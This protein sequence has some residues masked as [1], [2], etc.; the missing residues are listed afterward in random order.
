MSAIDRPKSY[1]P[2][3]AAKRWS[4]AWNAAGVYTADP[5][6]PGEPYSIVIPPPNVTGSLHMGHALNNTLQDVLIRYKR[7]DGYNVL[8]VPGTDHAGIA[9]QWVVRKQLAADGVDFWELGRDKFVERVWE[10]KEKAGGRITHQLRELGVSCDWSRERFTLDEDL[11]VAVREHFVRLYEQGLIYRGERLINWD[12]VDQTA[13]SNLEVEYPKDNDGN[14][15]LEQGELWSFAY[16]ISE[17]DGGGEIVV[18]TT[19]PETMLGDTAVA[20]HPDDERYKHLI[21]KSVKHP[22]MDRDIPIVADAILV[23]MEFGTGCVKITPA[24]DFNDFAVGQR[25]GLQMINIFN[26]DATVNENG[27]KYEGLDRYAARD[28]VKADIEAAG[29]F[30]GTKEHLMAIGRGQRSGAV[31]EPML[32]TQ[33]FVTMK[34]LAGP[35]LAAVEQGFT[36]FVPKQWENTYYAWLRDIRDWCIS[37]QLWWG[38]RIP[39]WFDAEGNVFVAR[40]FEEA[41]EQAGTTE[42]T[43]DTDVLDTWFS[44]ALWPFSVFGWPEKTADLDKYYPTSVLITGFDIIFFW[45]ARMMF[46]GQHFTGSVPFKDVYIHALVRDKNGHKMSKTKGNVVDPLD[47]IDKWGADAFRYTLVDFAAQGRDIIWNEK[48]IEVNRN[49]TTKI[50]Q[51]LNY[52]FHVGGDYDAA[53]PMEFGVY[54]HWI[55][56][57]TGAAVGRIRAALDEYKFNEAARELTD[58]TYNE[59]CGWYIELS[60]STVYDAD[61]SEARKNGT[62]HVLFETMGALARLF[63]PM[64]PFMSEEIW[65][66]LPGTEGLITVAPYPKVSD[67]D[68]DEQVLSQVELLQEAI[69]RV[70][71]IRGEMEIAKS[72]PMRLLTADTHLREA[73]HPYGRA[74]RELAGIQ[75]IEPLVDRPGFVATAVVGGH[76]VVIPLD[77]IVDKE[78]ERARLNK[79]IAK[80]TKAVSRLERQVNNPKFI[81]NA[82]AEKVAA[83]RE[84]YS[85][86]SERIAMLQKSLSRLD[87]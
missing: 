77:G 75:S 74:L 83:T 68:I 60:K 48:A 28:A 16:P 20:V 56:A 24:H 81:A 27:G 37:R 31:V 62:R 18:A 50:W 9:T 78:A 38:H 57:R 41:A 29:L 35:A 63:H 58:F 12:P 2:H 76:E 51:A 19:R 71:T 6:A 46:A 39:A 64:M 3:A 23:D 52:C 54:E 8:W 80:A 72:K 59:Y 61:A 84:Q 67:Y 55:R 21:G 44:S 47:M 82:N 7:M 43:Q 4:A 13:L 15:I 10:W 33:W 87:A 30:R 17:A 32:S 66:A 5:S 40:S 85:L 22:F 70:R 73:L 11:K 53:A 69:T 36:R 26:K 45:V 25:H 14:K 49:F 79:T 1:D 65:E 42:L 86:E 34:P